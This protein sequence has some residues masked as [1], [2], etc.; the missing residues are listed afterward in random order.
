MCL[1]YTYHSLENRRNS[2]AIIIVLCAAALSL[3]SIVCNLP[4]KYLGVNTKKNFK[5]EEKKDGGA[6]QHTESLDSSVLALQ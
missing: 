2:F 4:L 6:V 3:V 1:A 5:T